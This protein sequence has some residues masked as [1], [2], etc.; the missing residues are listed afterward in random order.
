MICLKGSEEEGEWDDLI[1]CIS[2][3]LGVLERLCSQREIRIQVES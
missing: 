3:E 1:G 2:R